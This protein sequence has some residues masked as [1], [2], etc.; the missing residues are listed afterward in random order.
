MA[1]NALILQWNVNSYFTKFSELKLL[2]HD[3]APLCVCLQETLGRQGHVL[4]PPSQYNIECSPAV[5]NDGHERGAA[6]LIHKRISYSRIPLH[7]TL[8]AAAVTLYLQRKY[9]VCSLYLPHVPL[10]RAEL[11]QLL[12]QLPHPF[13]LLG[14]MNAHSSLWG[15]QETVPDDRGRLFEN[16]LNDH[17]I[18]LLNDHSPTHYHVQT[19]LVTSHST[20]Q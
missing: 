17:P 1:P 12:N 15:A 10:A 9:T 11:E 20:T 16:I 3:H 7:T 13:I 2:L 6:V 4:Y 14:D 18:S 8:Q 5:R 19:G